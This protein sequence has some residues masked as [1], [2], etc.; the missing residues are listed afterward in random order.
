MRAINDALGLEGIVPST[1][2]FSEL[3]SVSL[4]NGL[5]WLEN[6][7]QDRS[8]AASNT[9][10]FMTPHL[11]KYETKR[12]PKSRTLSTLQHVHIPADRVL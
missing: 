3:L 8:M 12:A 9:R 5:F 10:T 2:V 11:A 4:L 7:L 1:L 6:T